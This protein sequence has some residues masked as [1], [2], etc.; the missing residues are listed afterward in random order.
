MT[1]TA[2]PPCAAISL[3]ARSGPTAGRSASRTS[4]TCLC[5]RRRAL[6]AGSS[7]RRS[8]RRTIFARSWCAE[9]RIGRTAENCARR[10][11]VP[12]AGVRSVLLL[13]PSG[14]CFRPCFCPGCCRGRRLGSATR[15]IL[16][17]AAPRARRGRRPLARLVRIPGRIA[18]V[19][20]PKAARGGN[21]RSTQD[22]TARLLR[23]L[24]IISHR[25]QA[26]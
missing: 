18:R 12:S 8:F 2:S 24:F 16:T 25:S 13:G 26:M 19:D 9:S 14:A 5:Q 7:R 23:C 21:R 1:G 17:S 10:A 4:S 20:H 3:R 22:Q 6:A 11:C 15:G